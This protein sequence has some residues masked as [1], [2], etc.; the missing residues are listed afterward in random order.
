MNHMLLL[1]GLDVI[2]G[3]GQSQVAMTPKGG[4]VYDL[5]RKMFWHL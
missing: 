2:D 5:I 1:M 3:F 4:H